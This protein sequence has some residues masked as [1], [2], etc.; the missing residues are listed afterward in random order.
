ML[1]ITGAL[2]WGARLGD[3][4]TF[5]V[6][7]GG[8]AAFATPVAAVAL[9]SI[10][11]RL[12]ATGHGPLAVTV[13]PICGMQ[14]GLGIPISVVR[15]QAFGPHEYPPVPVAILEEIRSLPPEAKL[16]YACRPSEELAFWDP[17]LIGIDAH[18]ERRI[19]P[20]C[21]QADFFGQLIGGQKSTDTPGPLFQW[22][23]QRWLYLDSGAR[24]SAASVA[25]FLKDNGIDNLY[26]DALHPN[27]LVPGAIPIATVGETQV[28]RLP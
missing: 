11:L 19:V 22:A 9:W 21:F 15:L 25:S 1:L 12:R 5:H 4:N 7:F 18:T 6:F 2:V 17:R 13:V 8:I 20:M 28:L 23:P 24:P 14:I 3:F 10:W 26:T 16:A 27:A